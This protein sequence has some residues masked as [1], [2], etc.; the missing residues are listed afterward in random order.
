MLFLYNIGIRIYYCLVWAASLYN[1][2]AKNWIQGRKKWASLIA[3]E[4]KHSK[5]AWFHFASLGEFE[6]GKPLIQKFK[7]NCPEYK[8][9]FTFFS[10][11]GYENLKN[12]PLADLVLYLPLD[13][14]HNAEK[15]LEALN[16]EIVF[17][18]KYEYWYHFFTEL[19]KRGI[20]LYIVSAI[21]RP[22]QIFFKFYGG[23]SRQILKCVTHFFV[24]NHT[25]NQ[26]LESIH[27]KNV[28][29]VGDTRF[30]SVTDNLKN[31]KPF[32]IISDFCEDKPILIAGS[33]WL[34]DEFLL[35]KLLP[36]FPEW[37]LIIVPHEIGEKRIHQIQELFPN[38]IRYSEIATNSSPNKAQKINANQHQTLIV[39]NIGM[40]SSLYKYGHIAYI[41]GGFGVGIHNTLE[42]A[43]FGLPILF[44]PK[45][46][47]FQEAKDLVKIQSGFSI[48]NFGEMIELF[49][50]LSGNKIY[51]EQAGNKAKV[52]VERHIGASQKIIDFVK[53]LKPFNNV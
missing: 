3:P 36:F 13:T 32:P 22:N 40:L 37:K 51:R 2:K 16:P 30:D 46:Q 35:A 21:F 23:F 9:I 48:S 31:V 27:L 15:F 43:T 25:S 7:D 8:I 34:K 33:T 28:S 50:K 1:Q 49:K 44:G 53:N 5:N 38:A 52:Y 11:S 4:F 39:D 41:G 18:T 20:S 19:K 12:S 17:V 45:Y 47:K 42:A 29:I 6:Q 26:L 14:K 24:Q 10:P